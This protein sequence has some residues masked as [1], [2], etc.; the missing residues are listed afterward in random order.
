MNGEYVGERVMYITLKGLARRVSFWIEKCVLGYVIGF[1]SVVC[2]SYVCVV[3]V[4][5]ELRSMDG[6]IPVKT[7]AT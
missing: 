7:L 3:F 1:D 5:I 4:V 2:V 6:K